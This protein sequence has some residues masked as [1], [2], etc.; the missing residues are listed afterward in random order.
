MSETVETIRCKGHT[1]EIKQD[2][3]GYNPRENDNICIIHTAHRN[4]SFGDKSYNDSDSIHEAER[5]AVRNGDI[6]LP[7]YMYEHSGI[8]ISL[9][10]F[11]CRWDSGQ[12]GFV[13]VPRKKIIEEFG[14]KIFTKKLK[15]K[16]LKWANIEVTELDSYLRGEV[17]GFVIDDGDSCWGYIGDMKYC[18][19]EAKGT[20]NCI[21]KHN[22]K[23]HCEIVKQWIK[24]KVPLQYRKTLAM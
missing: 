3:C 20:V 18:I 12:V 23:E 17:Y 1:I 4:Y 14:K 13:Q 21:V 9:S 24:N 19:E 22:I 10:P 11:S 15:E 5:E 8:T 7:L 2:D 6:V 16:A